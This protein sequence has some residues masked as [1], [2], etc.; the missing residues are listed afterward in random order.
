MRFPRV[1]IELN[2]PPFNNIRIT[3]LQENWRHFGLY[4]H[5]IEFSVRNDAMGIP[6][7]ELVD[8]IGRDI[9][10]DGILSR[11]IPE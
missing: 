6:I 8:G 1:I 3:R 9:I 5:Q 4:E 11:L 10:V 7:Y 2:D